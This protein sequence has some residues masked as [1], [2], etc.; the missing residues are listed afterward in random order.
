MNNFVLDASAI[1]TYSLAANKK[2]ESIL[3]PL[4]KKARDNLIRLF[5]SPVFYSESANA[6]RFE[7]ND[8]EEA[9]KILRQILRIP[10]NLVSITP[11]QYQ[12]VLKISYEN[13]TTV[14]DSLYHFIALGRN[15]TLLT[16]DKK[17]FQAAKHLNHI[18]YIG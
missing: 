11:I 12:A 17:Y 16:C 6:I 7:I 13:K 5:T 2:T 8:F 9:K 10:V 15:A 18:R 1:V 3:R 4:I 14:Y